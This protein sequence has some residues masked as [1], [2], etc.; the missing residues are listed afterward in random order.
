M[1]H[2]ASPGRRRAGHGLVRSGP[3]GRRVASCAV[4]RPRGSAVTRLSDIA[5]PDPPPAQPR[6]R[7]AVTLACRAGPRGTALA[8][9]R[10]SGSLR[11]VFPRSRTAGMEAIVV[12]T[13]GGLTGGD[14]F[15]ITAEAGAGSRL[16][17][18]TQAAERAYAAPPGPAARLSTRLDVARAARL[19]WLPQETILFDRSRFSRRTE[20]TLA[21]DAAL[22]FVEP[23]V[24]G[25]AAM[26]ERLRQAHFDDRLRVTRGGHELFRD[27]VTLSGDV[28]AHL[29]R[30]AIAD[31]A[32]AM[33]LVLLVAPEAAAP[34]APLRALLPATGGA[35]LLAEDVLCAR[36]LA[37]YGHTLR[38]SLVPAL[39]L[40]NRGPLPRCWMI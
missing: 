7:G 29:A 31:G 4:N 25:R 23:V 27:G 19:A 38:A 8:D 21:P 30:P 34:L 26:G 39:T 15:S 36:I 18:S 32:G 6:A 22:L 11:L 10:Q 33:A 40:L 24:F 9:L 14:R 1:R 2:P 5:L 3:R 37:P 35:S 13:A 28:E 17:L 12:N 20:V 16:T